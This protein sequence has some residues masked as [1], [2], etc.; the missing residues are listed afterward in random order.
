MT[1]TLV[2]GAGIGSIAAAARLAYEGYQATV[3]KKKKTSNPD[4]VAVSS[5]KM[6]TISII[7][8]PCF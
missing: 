4:G 8:S 6:A 1:Y 2:I 5:I 3:E 7:V